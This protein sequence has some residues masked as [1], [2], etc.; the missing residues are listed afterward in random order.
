MRPNGSELLKADRLKAWGIRPGTWALNVYKQVLDG[1]TRAA[2][3]KIGDG[4]FTIVH[5]PSGVE[6]LSR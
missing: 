3:D 4:L 6:K 1:A 5:E 2:V